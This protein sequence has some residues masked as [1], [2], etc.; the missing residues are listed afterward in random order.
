M[1]H[2]VENLG[3]RVYIIDL[4]FMHQ[5]SRNP[6]VYNEFILHHINERSEKSTIF[7]RT[8]GFSKYFQIGKDLNGLFG[9]LLSYNIPNE[10]RKIIKNVV[11]LSKK[12]KKMNRYFIDIPNKK[13]SGQNLIKI[14]VEKILII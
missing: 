12:N 14:I 6:N 4:P 1:P 10:I 8:F 3:Y 7:K 2:S 9:N 5:Y 13:T 11:I